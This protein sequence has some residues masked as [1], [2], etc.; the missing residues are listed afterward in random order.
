MSKLTM[1]KPRLGTAAVNNLKVQ[2]PGSWNGA[3][4][5]SVFY[6]HRWRKA[7]DSYLLRNPLC[8]HCLK[9]KRATAENLEVDHVI[10]HRGD[11][12][13]FWDESNWQTLCKS[14][15]SIKTATVD[16]RLK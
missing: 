12:E 5:S 7:R 1:L 9:E 6:N 16:S 15:H 3:R 13:L 11:M 4:S 2:T 8:V 10:P 14:H